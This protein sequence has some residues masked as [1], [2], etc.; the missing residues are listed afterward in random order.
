[1]AK[2]NRSHYTK[3]SWLTVA[4]NTGMTLMLVAVGAALG[5][6]LSDLV[7]ADYAAAAAPATTVVT[8][9]P[10]VKPQLLAT[11]ISETATAIPT[12]TPIASPTPPPTPT[13]IP[14]TPTPLPPT[15]TPLPTAYFTA[16]NSW[17]NVRSGPDLHYEK[18]GT[19]SPGEQITITGT[20][21]GWWQIEFE[22][23]SAW[24]TGDYGTAMHTVYVPDV[25]WTIP[26]EDDDPALW[27]T[28]EERWIDIDLSAQTL[29]AYEGQTLVKEYLISSGLDR[30]PTP[31]GQYRIWIKLR[32]DDM[33]GAD[34][35]IPNVPYVMYFHLGYGLHGVT[36]HG[37]FGHPMSHGCINQPTDMAGW[38]FD[39][40]EVG[41]LVNIHQ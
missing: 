21:Q 2:N 22:E 12:Q 36:W 7:E 20:W 27:V 41:T 39:F 6:M 32:Y 3:L 33:S 19:I 1:M 40:A 31:T 38:L 4:Y 25:D 15:A 34:Y 5:Y 16:G 10:D 9:T 28:T 11:I 29:R 35:Y 23:R 26:G 18:L 30:T 17:I 37:N 13:P 24:I 8:A 14:P